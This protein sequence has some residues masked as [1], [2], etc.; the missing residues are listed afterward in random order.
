MSPQGYALVLQMLALHILIPPL[1]ETL[2]LAIGT[3]TGTVIRILMNTTV[4]TKWVVL[5]CLERLVQLSEN[6]IVETIHLVIGVLVM[7][8]AQN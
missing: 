2:T 3:R 7:P 1:V 8:T 4:A 6:M 5:G